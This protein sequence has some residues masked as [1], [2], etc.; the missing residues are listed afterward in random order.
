[1]PYLP[2]QRVVGIGPMAVLRCQT[3]GAMYARVFGYTRRLTSVSCRSHARDMDPTFERRRYPRKTVSLPADL[4]VDGSNL[5]CNVSGV[6]MTGL[7]VETSQ[8][9]HGAV[10]VK[11]TPADPSVRLPGVCLNARVVYCIKRGDVWRS[12][13]AAGRGHKRI[14][15]ALSG[16]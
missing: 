12:G 6:S 13:L 4:I 10:R 5:R 9:I 3:C 8:H 7:Q 14:L 1:M 11:F 2:W 15:R 16:E